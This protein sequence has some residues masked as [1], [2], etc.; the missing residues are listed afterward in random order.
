MYGPFH[1]LLIWQYLE[2]IGQSDAVNSSPT[3]SYYR[4]RIPFFFAKEG[5]LHL[6]ASCQPSLWTGGLMDSLSSQ[7]IYDTQRMLEDP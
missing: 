1:N 2:G 6:F 3:N 7:S 4:F 5:L